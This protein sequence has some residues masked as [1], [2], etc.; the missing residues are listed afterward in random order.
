MS[1]PASNSSSNIIDCLFPPINYAAVEED[2]YRSGLP[3][4]LN[5]AFVK[6]MNVKVRYM[7]Y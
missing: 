2:L 5:Y 4:E 3:T 1:A 7:Q 6:K